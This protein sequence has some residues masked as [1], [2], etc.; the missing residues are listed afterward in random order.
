MVM[1]SANVSV[2]YSTDNMMLYLRTKV[3]PRVDPTAS[4]NKYY[5]SLSGMRIM[6]VYELWC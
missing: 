5:A 4:Y 2:N 3:Q 6:A 1:C